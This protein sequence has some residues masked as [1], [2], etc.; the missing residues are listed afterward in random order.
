MERKSLT[1]DCQPDLSIGSQSLSIYIRTSLLEQEGNIKVPA[2]VCCYLWNIRN[3]IPDKA[4]FRPRYLD[5]GLSAVVDTTASSAVQQEV[6]LLHNLP[7][8]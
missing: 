8:D 3:E 5:L 6:Q 7:L 4:L 2:S 1:V